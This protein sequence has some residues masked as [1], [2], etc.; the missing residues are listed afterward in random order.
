[1]LW[2]ASLPDLTPQKI[3]SPVWCRGKEFTPIAEELKTLEKDLSPQLKSRW[4]T[5]RLA[6][7]PRVSLK[8]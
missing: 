8:D 4:L 3:L 6:H 7:M 1:M 2:F 5:E